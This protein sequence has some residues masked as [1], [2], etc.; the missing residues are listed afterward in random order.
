MKVGGGTVWFLLL[1]FFL[2]FVRLFSEPVRANGGGAETEGERESQ[3][4]STLSA[5]SL[6][7]GSNSPTARSQPEPRLSLTPNRLSHLSTS[8]AAF[9]TSGLGLI[10]ECAPQCGEW[11]QTGVLGLL[12]LPHQEGRRSSVWSQPPADGWPDC[13]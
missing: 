3:A 13:C 4:G 7:R 12:P 1:F 8:P 5:Q 6:T 9:L 11:L 10:W 2:M